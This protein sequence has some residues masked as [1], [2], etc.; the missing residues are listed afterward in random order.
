M[1]R[2]C[3]RIFIPVYSTQLCGKRIFILPFDGTVCIFVRIFREFMPY[4]A[5][6]GKNP[7]KIK[8]IIHI[9]IDGEI[10]VIAI[11]RPH[12]K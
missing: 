12:R 10:I 9:D 4:F 8:K 11:K 2:Q 3:R 1:R 7:K 6:Y 5:K